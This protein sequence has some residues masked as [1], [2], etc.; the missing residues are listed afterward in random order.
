MQMLDVYNVEEGV[1]TDAGAWVLRCRA[2]L[3]ADLAAES[4][5]SAW[6]RILPHVALF[7]CIQQ[8]LTGL[9]A[10]ETDDAA[11]TETTVFEL[12]GEDKPG[13]L[14]ETTRLLTANGCNVRSAA[15]S[16]PPLPGADIPQKAPRSTAPCALCLVAAPALV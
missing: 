8:D 14:S 12:A 2:H 4:F 15:V 3:H 5:V 9:C 16:L 1:I 6:Q 13:L 7:W 10:D 11:R